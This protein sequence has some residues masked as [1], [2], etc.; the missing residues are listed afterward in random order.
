MPKPISALA[1]HP[2]DTVATALVPLVS[3]SSVTLRS[4]T[5]HPITITIRDTIPLGHKFALIPIPRGEPIIKYGF[6]IGTATQ[7]IEP[8]EWV[9]THNLDGLR[10]RGDR[11][12]THQ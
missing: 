9:H 3:G 7:I 6:P 8:G 2:T 1:I 5:G 11:N 12:P 10:G 4:S